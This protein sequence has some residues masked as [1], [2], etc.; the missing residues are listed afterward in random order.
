M[1]AAAAA[2]PD[3]VVALWVT[4][5]PST[6]GEIPSGMPARFVLLEDGRVFVGGLSAVASAKLPKKDLKAIDKLVARVRKLPGL[7]S[8]VALGPG[9]HQFR[10][11][12][13]KGPEVL[14][15]GGLSGA[16]AAVRPLVQLVEA[17]SAFTHPELRPFSA[18]RFLLTLHDQT[19]DGGCREWQLPVGAAQLRQSPVVIPAA[20]ASGWP[21]G[22]YPASVC[23]GDRRY[24]VTLRPLVPGET[25]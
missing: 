9:D 14:A 11:F 23:E 2:P 5:G 12:L 25:P 22:G 3:T 18:D 15:R 1:P 16:P 24:A 21:T 6:R 19:L 4:G 8:T 17:L 7:T 13:R 20:A 10:L